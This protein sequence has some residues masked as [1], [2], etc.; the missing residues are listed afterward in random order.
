MKKIL[1]STVAIL[2]TGC[3]IHINEHQTPEDKGFRGH[4][5]VSIRSNDYAF[6]ADYGKYAD[7]FVPTDFTIGLSSMK[8]N[9][10]NDEFIKAFYESTSARTK[11]I[12][13]F[14]YDVIIDGK[15]YF[16]TAT[17]S[18]KVTGLKDL[19]GKHISFDLIRKKGATKSSGDSVPAG[20]SAQVEDSTLTATL[21][22]PELLEITSPDFD[23]ITENIP[24]CDHKN[25]VLRWNTD[26]ENENGVIIV[27][28]WLGEVLFGTSTPDTMIRR[29][30][31]VPDTGET[32]LRPEMFDGIPDT[33]FCYLAV[34]RGDIENIVI[35]EQSYQ[36]LAET[37]VI[38]PF[39][40]AKHTITI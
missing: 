1:Y 15:P 20:D 23:V 25:F 11:A 40:L 28:M 7:Y 2:I 8:S 26:S 5:E 22:I 21:Y 33:A 35:D 24:L 37:H 4:T 16:S 10:R 31:C 32:T 39:A 34:I 18:N 30:D 38:L 13:D 27:M 19:Y 6:P 14:E 36:I 17:K 9:P 12:T 3:S 29:V